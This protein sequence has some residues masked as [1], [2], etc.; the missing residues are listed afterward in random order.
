MWALG[1]GSTQMTRSPA[2]TQSNSQATLMWPRQKKK[3]K[4]Q[5]K[6]DRS[7][8]VVL[9]SCLV[10]LPRQDHSGRLRAESSVPR[11]AASSRRAQGLANSPRQRRSDPSRPPNSF[12]SRRGRS[13]RIRAHAPRRRLP[14]TRGAVRKVAQLGAASP[15]A[16]TWTHE[17][18]AQ[19]HWMRA[20]CSCPQN[21]Q[22][23]SPQQKSRHCR[24][25]TVWTPLAQD[26]NARCL[27]QQEA[28]IPPSR[29]ASLAMC[30]ARVQ[31]QHCR[32]KQEQDSCPPRWHP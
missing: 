5:K 2:H 24:G 25:S 18:W 11:R 7:S 16:S 12:S 8:R 30:G 14:A 13:R 15:N 3:I 29:H 32:N 6:V 10:T 4:K 17:L 27:P 22:P 21:Q 26:A 19:A 31:S 23:E 28:E 1:P 9:A 20:Q